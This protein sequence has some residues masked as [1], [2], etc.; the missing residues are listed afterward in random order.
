MAKTTRATL[1]SRVGYLLE[2]VPSGATNPTRTEITTWLNEGQRTISRM[3]PA[4]FL[5]DIIVVSNPTLSSGRYFY[6]LSSLTTGTF[7]KPHTC[8]VQA[9]NSGSFINA[10]LVTPEEGEYIKTNMDLLGTA[11]SP[12]YWFQG[13]FVYWWPAGSIKLTYIK[14]PEE[15]VSG[16]TEYVAIPQEFEDAVIYYA[17]AM[18]RAQDE[19]Y[20]QYG[21]MMQKFQE[22]LMAV[23]SG[24][25]RS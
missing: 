20:E 18:A 21:A 11:A 7:L 10:R 25:K 22:S 17:V 1:I 6:T 24:Y 16:T 23:A 5:R 8:S 9:A 3:L 13:L 4:P 15:L 2:I 19:E 14:T 12:I